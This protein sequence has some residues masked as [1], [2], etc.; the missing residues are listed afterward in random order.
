MKK[1]AKF[2]QSR[3]SVRCLDVSFM[4]MMAFAFSVVVTQ[5][6]F[7]YPIDVGER[8][9]QPFGRPRPSRDLPNLNDREASIPKGYFFSN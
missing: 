2:F 5:E 8:I 4:P 7:A 6:P 1:P 3:E 9:L